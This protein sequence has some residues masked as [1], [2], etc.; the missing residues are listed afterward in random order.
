MIYLGSVVGAIVEMLVCKL[1]CATDCQVEGLD[2]CLRSFI[3]VSTA[4]SRVVVCKGRCERA[5]RRQLELVNE[6]CALS[7][8]ASERTSFVESKFT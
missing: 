1:V 6:P 7:D 2:F 5:A 4:A 3:S 8:E